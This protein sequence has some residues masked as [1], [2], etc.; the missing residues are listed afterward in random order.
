[1]AELAY[2]QGLE[3]CFV[4]T[5]CGFKS[6]PQHQYLKKLLDEFFEIFL[7]VGFEREG[8]RENGSF[9]VAEILKPMGFKAQGSDAHRTPSSEIPTPSTNP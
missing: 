3:P 6:H 8:G 5:N 4:Q 2:A 1:M 7:L 9:P